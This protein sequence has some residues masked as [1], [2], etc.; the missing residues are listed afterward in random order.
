ML[1]MTGLVMGT[2][3]RQPPGAASTEAS[4][5][6]VD[7][8]PRSV[9]VDGDPPSVSVDGDPPQSDPDIY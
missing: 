5:E 8:D 1:L 9:S 3:Q 7:G 4:I 6:A 2:W